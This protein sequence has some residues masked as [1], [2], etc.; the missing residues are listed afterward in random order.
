ML[1]G[2]EPSK[3]FALVSPDLVKKLNE[4]GSQNDAPS[5][6]VLVGARYQG[7][8][9]GNVADFSM[10]FDIFS[11]VDKAEVLLPLS[12]VELREG[13]LLDGVAVFPI[14][15]ERPRPGYL[16]NVVGK[17]RHHLALPAAVRCASTGSYQ[18]LRFSGP[19]LCSNLLEWRM[20]GPAFGLQVVGALGDSSIRQVSAASHEL[21]ANLGAEPVVHLRWQTKAMPFQ[22]AEAEVHEA[23]Y[24]DLRAGMASL[25]GLVRFTPSKGS[26]SH[27]TIDLPENM[28]VRNLNALS[29]EFT[30]ASPVV[31]LLKTWSISGAGAERRLRVE[32]TSP[33]THR[34]LLSINLVPHVNLGERDLLGFTVAAGDQ[35]V[36]EFCGL[37]TGRAGG[38][39]PAA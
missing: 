22:A 35:A 7:K 1:V 19:R 39:G 32:L 26:L 36:R 9:N 18:D 30:L 37:S 31:S 29:G 21:R 5:R 4:L 23:Y 8:L 28:E 34:V 14:A 3:Q 16:V 11:F 33:V 12:D 13:A 10:Q 6:A 24:W 17:G 38:V 2:D 25:S 15:S 27:L 20:D